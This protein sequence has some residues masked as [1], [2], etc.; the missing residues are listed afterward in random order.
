[1]LSFSI[2]VTLSIT[3][4]LT[5]KRYFGNEPKLA[6]MRLMQRGDEFTILLESND[7]MSTRAC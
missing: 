4:I 2:A 5:I 3:L 7:L 6:Q 1:V